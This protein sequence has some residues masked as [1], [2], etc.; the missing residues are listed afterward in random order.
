MNVARSRDDT[1]SHGKSG[2]LF[3]VF[4][5]SGR[6]HNF[7]FTRFFFFLSIFPVAYIF[8]V[9]IILIFS[10]L[11]VFLYFASSHDTCR[12]YEMRDKRYVVAVA[13]PQG[14]EKYEPL[15]ILYVFRQRY[16]P[17]ENFSF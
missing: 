12:E 7:F 6:L 1:F 5:F 9:I 17:V 13:N 10:S 16:N 2:W 14:H 4:S 15:C 11:S 3:F 8:G